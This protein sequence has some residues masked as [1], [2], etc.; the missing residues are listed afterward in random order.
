VIFKVSSSIVTVCEYCNCAVARGDRQLEDLGKVADLVDTGS[1][2]RIGLKGIY[3]GAPFELV[4]RA[5]FEH[6]AGGIWDEWYAAFA[7][8]RWGWLAEAQGRFYMTF[9]Q[10]LPGGGLIPPFEALELGRGI[11]TIPFIVAEKGVARSLGAKGEIPYRLMPGQEHRYAD[12]SGPGGAFG[13]IDYSQWPPIIFIGREIPL[14]ELGIP[15]IS[16]TK[17]EEARRVAAVKLS[18]PKCGGPLELRAPDQA[19]RV[20]CQNCGS[21]LDVNQGQLAFLSA[22]EPRLKPIIPLGSIGKFAE[23]DLT[24]IGF[25]Q[26]S[27]VLGGVKYYWEEY[28]LYNPRVGFRWLVRSDDH[29]NYV[30]PIP[31][32]E[33]AEGYRQARFRKKR[34]KLFQDALA[35]VEHVWGE[36]YWKVTVGETVR[37]SDYVSPPEMLSK[38]VS[39]TVIEDAKQDQAKTIKQRSKRQRIRQSQEINWSLGLYTKPEE[40]ESAFGIKGLPRPS[41]I[42]PNQPFPHKAIYKYWGIMLAAA[43]LLGLIFLAI[44]PRKKVFEAQYVLQPLQNADATE[45]IFTDQFE[46]RSWQNI[47]VTAT[48]LVNNSWLYIEGDFINDSSGLVEQ[49]SLPV[50]YYYGV[51]DGEQWSEGSSTASTYLSALPGGKYTLRL[52]ASWQNW[53]QAMPLRIRIEQGVP[54]VLHLVLTLIAL[55][56]LPALVMIRHYSFERRRWEDSNYNPFEEVG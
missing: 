2:L 10:P 16:F 28:L 30:L 49:F 45:V 37:A 48:A 13:T 41:N 18:C 39:T 33:V 11:P 21:L 15:E 1:L 47:K 20:T 35:R 19:Q 42:A 31:P 24:V 55:S 34:F 53:N 12:L 36:F 23:G 6:E 4:G 8:G 29:W 3:C 9:E 40:I 25:L 50:E 5:Q 44:G 43:L 17:E 52:E 26:R 22:L 27:V 51:E 14:S 56:I 54:R 7:D 38:E 46:L 32:G